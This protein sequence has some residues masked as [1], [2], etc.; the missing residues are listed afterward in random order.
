MLPFSLSP[1]ME[2]FLLCLTCALVLA[3][4]LFTLFLPERWARFVILPS[5]PLH[6]LLIN[7]LFALGATVDIVALVLLA[8]LFVYVGVYAIRA[9]IG[10]RG[11]KGDEV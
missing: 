6:L 9:E 1:E 11:G 2:I 5:V 3:C 7:A 8:L 4:Y 10:K